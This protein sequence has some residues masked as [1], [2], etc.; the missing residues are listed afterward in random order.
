MKESSPPEAQRAEPD[1]SGYTIDQLREI[2]FRQA[3]ERYGG[4]KGQRFRVAKSLN[5][6]P[7]TAFRWAKEFG[8][9]PFRYNGDN[10]N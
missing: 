3:W 6:A 10:R 1:L 7:M 2:A 5:I 4:V 8:L 9:I